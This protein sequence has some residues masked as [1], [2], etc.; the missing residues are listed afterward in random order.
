MVKTNQIVE[1]FLKTLKKGSQVKIGVWCS[2]VKFALEHAP[3]E[4][5]K[6]PMRG[7]KYQGTDNFGQQHFTIYL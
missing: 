7:W 1:E 6:A 2:E 3:I 5:I 4:K